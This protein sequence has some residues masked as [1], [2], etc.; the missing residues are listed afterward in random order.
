MS[1]IRKIAVLT[2]GGDAP[3]MNSAVRAVV[4]SAINSGIEI[5][6]VMRG[7]EGLIDWETQPLGLADVRNIKKREIP[8]ERIPRA[9]G[10]ESARSRCRC[11]CC[12]RWGW[13]TPWSHSISE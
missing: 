10:K 5:V 3:G 6:G 9:G 2:S 12:H 8:S 11:A 7:Y 13:N 4:V 1:D